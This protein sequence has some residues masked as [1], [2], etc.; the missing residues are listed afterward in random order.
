MPKVTDLTTK[1]IHLLG[2]MLTGMIKLKGEKRKHLGLRKRRA[3]DCTVLLLLDG[4][5]AHVE[6]RKVKQDILNVLCGHQLIN[7]RM[8]EVD[9]HLFIGEWFIN[10]NILEAH[11]QFNEIKAQAVLGT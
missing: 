10:E 7:M 6:H 3:D 5:S 8:P 4:E 2:C 9:T 1:E 11:P